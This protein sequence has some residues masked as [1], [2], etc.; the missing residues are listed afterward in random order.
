MEDCIDL[1]VADIG[2]ERMSIHIDCAVCG[3]D[4]L[5]GS[6]VG[7]STLP[8]RKI[9]RAAVRGAVAAE[10]DNDVVSFL[11]EGV[12]VKTMERFDDIC[13]RG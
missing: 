6:S 3:T 4:G 13:T 12:P 9:V 5:D 8:L 2:N 11:N 10:V 7:G 1:P